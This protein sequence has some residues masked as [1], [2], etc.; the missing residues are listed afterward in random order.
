MDPKTNPVKATRGQKVIVEIDELRADGTG[1]TLLI[2]YEDGT[3]EV[4][5]NVKH[6]ERS[7][8]QRAKAGNPGVTVTEIEW[9]DGLVPSA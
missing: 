5:R 4:A 9:R 3:V 8:R 1:G 6:A 2:M 7:I